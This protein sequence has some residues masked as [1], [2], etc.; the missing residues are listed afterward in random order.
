MSNKNIFYRLALIP[1]QLLHKCFS[2]NKI[3]SS[4]LSNYF[5]CG[6]RRV[7]EAF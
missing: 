2:N 3:D 5:Y 6:E 4:S 1:G 7:R